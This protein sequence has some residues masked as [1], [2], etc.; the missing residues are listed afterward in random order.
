MSANG[1]A[2]GPMVHA[3]VHVL[4]NDGRHVVGT[5]RGFDQVTNVILEDCAE[6]VYS[7]ESGV[8]EAPLGVYM[9]RGDNVC[10]GDDAIDATRPLVGP[11]D[12]EL[13]AKL[14]LS[15]TRALPLKPI[16]F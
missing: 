16:K 15:G 13:D 7:S 9:I 8:E 4:T 5:L 6:R 3:R 14:D 12:E 10:V 11:V 2:L 1:G